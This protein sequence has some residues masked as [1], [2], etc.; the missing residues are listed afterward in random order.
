MRPPGIGPGSHAWEACILPLNHERFTIIFFSIFF[1]TEQYPFI[2][3]FKHQHRLNFTI[4]VMMFL[5]VI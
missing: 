3:F 2:T 1:P 4:T 5:L